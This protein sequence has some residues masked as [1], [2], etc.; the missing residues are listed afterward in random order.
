MNITKEDL[1]KNKRLIFY[2][3]SNEEVQFLN[4]L[5][6]MTFIKFSQLKKMY[7]GLLVYFYLNKSLDQSKFELQFPFFGKMIFDIDELKEKI[8][9]PFQLQNEE[10]EID[11]KLRLSSS[12]KDVVKSHLEK[13]SVW[14]EDLFLTTIKRNLEDKLL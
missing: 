1:K 10:I 2:K 12:L 8:N 14:L 9:Y 13:K 11:V 6:V 3:L 7:M 4:E 5:S